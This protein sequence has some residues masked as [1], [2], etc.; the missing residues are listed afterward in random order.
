[1]LGT[2]AEIFV[3]GPQT[4]SMY[5]SPWSGVGLLS[6]QAWMPAYANILHSPRQGLDLIKN[7][8]FARQV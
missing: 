5:F 7:S 8:C 1:M 3:P 4:Y 6:V 2:S